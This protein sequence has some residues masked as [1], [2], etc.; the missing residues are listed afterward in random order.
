MSCTINQVPSEQLNVQLDPVA[1]ASETPAQ[2]VSGG[3]SAQSATASNP[4]DQTTLSPL[5]QILDSVTQNATPTS[6]FRPGLVEYL[7]G[8]IANGTYQPNADRVAQ[9]V[10]Q[11]LSSLR[12]ASSGVGADS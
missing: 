4:V 3:A 12:A 11:A 5:G 2:L 7:R 10:A 1:A 9:R 8:A 6:S